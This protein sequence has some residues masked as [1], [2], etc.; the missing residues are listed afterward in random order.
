MSYEGVHINRPV[1]LESLPAITRL[2]SALMIELEGYRP[3]RKV[4]L[5]VLRRGVTRQIEPKHYPKIVHPMPNASSRPLELPTSSL[6]LESVN[7]GRLPTINLG[8]Q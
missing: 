1:A 2:Q 4:N 7:P 3:F 6:A 5:T 8:L